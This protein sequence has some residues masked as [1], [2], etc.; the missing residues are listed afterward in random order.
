MGEKAGFTGLF[1][2]LKLFYEYIFLIA[3]LIALLN[4]GVTLADPV[5]FANCVSPTIKGG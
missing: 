3:A 2:K 1:L 4:I 5:G